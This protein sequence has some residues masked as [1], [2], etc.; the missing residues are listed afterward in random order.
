MDLAPQQYDYE[1]PYNDRRY[2][3]PVTNKKKRAKFI[4]GMKKPMENDDRRSWMY[5]ENGQDEGKFLHAY[6]TMELRGHSSMFLKPIVKMKSDT[7]YNGEI[8]K[9]MSYQMTLTN[10]SYAGDWQEVITFPLPKIMDEIR[11]A[12]RH[13]IYK[14][15]QVFWKGDLNEDGNEDVIIRTSYMSDS[16]GGSIVQQTWNSRSVANLLFGFD[17][18]FT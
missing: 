6:E 14:N 9:L 16:C 13:T 3:V 12:D 4:V 5:N 17:N 10:L 15:P 8:K 2:Y 7:S 18:T 11:S 1:D